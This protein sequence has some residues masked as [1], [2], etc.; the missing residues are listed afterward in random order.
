MKP[1]ENA[2]KRKKKYLKR[3]AQ[4]SVLLILLTIQ[5]VM[6]QT[7]YFSPETVLATYV[8]EVLKVFIYI[9]LAWLLLL[10]IR[11]LTKKPKNYEKK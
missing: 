8:V 6:L 9:N 11:F 4:G 10:G 5:V 7:E 3:I 1:T 2:Q